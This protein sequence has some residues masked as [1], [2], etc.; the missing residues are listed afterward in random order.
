MKAMVW[1][2]L[3]L[4]LVC[5]VFLFLNKET[6]IIKPEQTIQS[7]QED[8]E[9]CPHTRLCEVDGCFKQGT[10][11]WMDASGALEYY[12]VEHFEKMITVQNKIEKN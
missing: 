11:V 2:L 3:V 10:E 6:S 12:C 8:I 9:V 7:I 5:C 1:I 4:V